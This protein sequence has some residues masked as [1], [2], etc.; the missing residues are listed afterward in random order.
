MS[1]ANW[2]GTLLPWSVELAGLKERLGSL[3][4]RSET[5]AQAG[6]YLDGLIGGVE[7]KNAWQLAEHAGDEAPWRM[8]AVLGRGFW[9]AEQARDCDGEA[10][11]ETLWHG[12]LPAWSVVVLVGWTAALGWGASRLFRWH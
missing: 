12:S 10:M 3:F 9:D 2:S 4:A 11:R 6:L 5:R 1:I 7:R 8:Q